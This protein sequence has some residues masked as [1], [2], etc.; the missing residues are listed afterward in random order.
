MRHFA[1]FLESPCKKDFLYYELY[2]IFGI[3]SRGFC[4]LFHFWSEK[5]LK[6]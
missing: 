2:Y 6:I 5:L 1:S 3:S 4:I